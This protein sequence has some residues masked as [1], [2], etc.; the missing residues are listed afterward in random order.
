MATKLVLLSGGLDSLCMT[1]L[2]LKDAKDHE[3]H[4]HHINITNVEGRASAEAT[5]VNSAIEYFQTNNYPK[6]AYTES[7]IAAP[8]FGRSFMY[9]SDAVNF[10]AGY[11]CSMNPT[12]TEVA[13]GLNKSDT[14]GPN[15]TRIQKANQLLALFTSATK[16]Y[17]VKDYTK[18]EMYD[19]LPEEL[20][21]TF[22]SCRTPKYIDDK[23]HTCGH[24]HTCMQIQKLL[25]NQPILR[26]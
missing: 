23:A 5:A 26:P 14:N 25:L 21:T 3:I 8:N 18:Q 6:F 22:W 10:M 7:T 2:I 11:I 16:I 4:I 15:T 12:I 1:H 20:K 19:L 17:P 24:C 9:D 13:I